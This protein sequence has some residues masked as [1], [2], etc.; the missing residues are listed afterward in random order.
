ME[1]IDS[2]EAPALHR[3]AKHCGQVKPLLQFEILSARFPNHRVRPASLN[4]EQKGCRELFPIHS[5]TAL[6]NAFC[7]TEPDDNCLAILSTAVS[8]RQ[9]ARMSR[10]SLAGGVDA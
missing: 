1:Y 4:P 5:V 3:C 10:A 2:V 8:R 6:R 9:A 7:R